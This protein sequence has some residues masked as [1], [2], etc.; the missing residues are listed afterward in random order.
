MICNFHLRRCVLQTFFNFDF[1]SMAFSCTLVC[2][3]Y[4][5]PPWSVRCIISCTP[6]L[7][8]CLF[9]LSWQLSALTLSS[10]SPSSSAVVMAILLWRIVLFVLWESVLERFVLVLQ[11]SNAS[12]LLRTQTFKPTDF[13]A[14]IWNRLFQVDYFC[15]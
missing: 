14:L 5:L 7:L 9:L 12:I 8:V 13:R 10:L 3:K 1:S 6:S 15:L 11:L 4:L 2:H